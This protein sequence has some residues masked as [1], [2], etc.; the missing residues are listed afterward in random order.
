MDHRETVGGRHRLPAEHWISK[1]NVVFPE[2][3]NVAHGRK[4]ERC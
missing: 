1:L 2:I 3:T 4:A